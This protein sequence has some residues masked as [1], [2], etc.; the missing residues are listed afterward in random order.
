M[1]SSCEHISEPSGSISGRL[2]LVGAVIGLSRRPLLMNPVLAY[3][4]V[5]SKQESLHKAVIISWVHC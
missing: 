4:F 2:F 1:T 5:S 3:N